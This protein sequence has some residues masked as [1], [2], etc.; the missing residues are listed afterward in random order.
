LLKSGFVARFGPER[1]YLSTHA[2]MRALG[3]D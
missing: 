2:A 1:F 3:C